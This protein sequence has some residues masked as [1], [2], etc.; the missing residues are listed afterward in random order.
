MLKPDLSPRSIFVLPHPAR[1]TPHAAPRTPELIHHETYDSRG[2]AHQAL[3]EYIECS[4][5]E[6]VVTQP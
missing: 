2:A 3:F 6:I 1:R 4:I 5:T